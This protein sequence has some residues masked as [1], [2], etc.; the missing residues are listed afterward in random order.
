MSGNGCSC[1]S[2]PDAPSSAAPA[3]NP[4]GSGSQHSESVWDPLA[5]PGSGSEYSRAILTRGANAFDFILFGIN[6]AGSY[7]TIVQAQVSSDGINWTNAGSPV[8]LLG[9]GYVASSAITGNGFWC[10]RFICLNQVANVTLFS[11]IVRFY[12]G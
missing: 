9:P 1:S 12:C 10:V 8:Q 3:S 11:C 6:S 2:T 7:Q 4:C 5:L